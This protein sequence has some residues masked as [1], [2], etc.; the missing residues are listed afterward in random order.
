MS[1]SQRVRVVGI[2]SPN[3]DDRLGWLVAAALTHSADMAELRRYGVE[4]SRCRHPA[5]D[6][7]DRVRYADLAILIDA[8]RSAAPPGT[9]YRLEDDEIL[10]SSDIYSSHGLGVASMLALGRALGELPKRLVLYG[11][12]AGENTPD[13]DQGTLVQ[14]VLAELITKIRCDLRV[15][16]LD[17]VPSTRAS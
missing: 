6:L 7:L 1:R 4:V 15:L 5:V 9:L 8:V 17:C 16:G 10:S 14:R 2:G 11:V 12:A 13:P 3:G